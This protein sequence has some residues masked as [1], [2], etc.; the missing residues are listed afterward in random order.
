MDQRGQVPQLE[1][2]ELLGCVDRQPSHLPARKPRESPVNTGST[3]IV[4][5]QNQST[6]VVALRQTQWLLLVVWRN[7]IS[8]FTGQSVE[9]QSDLCDIQLT[10]LVL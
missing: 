7:H 9:G 8:V 3:L 10:E 2:C 1:I 5:S 4:R 6:G